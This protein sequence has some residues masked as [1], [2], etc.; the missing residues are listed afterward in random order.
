MDPT[1]IGIWATVGMVSMLLLRIPISVVLVAT[2]YTGLVI[3]MAGRGGG[4]DLEL[5]F[6]AA[7]SFLGELPYSSTAEYTFVTIP[8]FLLMGY[9]ATEAGFTKDL[10]HTARMW[11]GRVPGGLAVASS[12][13]C[14]LFAAISGSSL[15]TAAAMGRMAVPEMLARGYDKGL[16][17][18]VVAA[19]GTLGSLIPPSILMI[20]YAVFT[21]QSIA[22]MFVAG[23]I[24]G[25]LSLLIYVGM[26]MIRAKINPALAPPTEKSTWQEKFGSLKSTWG[27]LL[28]LT[29]VV[30]GLYTGMFTPS[31]AGAIGA[32]IAFL[33]SLFSRR[34]NREKTSSAL[35]ETL[36]STS[37]LFAAVI[38]AYMVT[39]FTALTGIAA[40]L[41]SW[42]GSF[43][44]HPIV[45]IASLSLLYIFLGTFMGSIEIMLLTLPIVIPIVKGL[46]YDL[47]WFGIIMIKYLEIGLVSPPVGINCFILKSV[48]NDDVRLSQIFRGVSWFIVM[49]IITIALLVIFPEIVTFLPNLM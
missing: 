22:A 8:M 19:S 23:I 32:A 15:A 26:V 28:L 2:G 14:A 7:N 49:D 39:S 47:I 40:E 41:T 13:G 38:G 44:V 9:I 20:L 12:V 21:D 18:G 1:T 37:M 27:M 34:I 5:G 3:V 6:M 31:E 16:A 17:T 29:V 35:L 11:L 45:V 30:S 33:I 24:P 46:D 10:Y 25:L 42:A 36:K 48:V 43:D 4:F